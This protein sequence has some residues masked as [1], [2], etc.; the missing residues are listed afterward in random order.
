MKIPVS[1]NGMFNMADEVLIPVKKADGTVEKISLA[2]FQARQKARRKPVATVS[3]P[4]AR[5]VVAPRPAVSIPRSSAPAKIKEEPTLEELP[6]TGSGAPRVSQDRKVDAEAIVRKLNLQISADAR[7]RLIGLI[8]L[9]LKDVRGEDEVKEWL[10]RSDKQYGIGLDNATADKVLV[11]IGE[12]TKKNI[13][14]PVDAPVLKRPL[15]TPQTLLK[16]DQEPFPATS[17]PIN[18]FVHAPYGDAKKIFTTPKSLDD[19]AR[20][21]SAKIGDDIAGMIPRKEMPARAIVRDIT[22]AKPANLG[23][24]DEIRYFTLTDFRRLSANPSEAAS[25][26]AQKFTNLRDES[27]I[28]YMNALEAWRGSPLFNDY[29]GASASSLNLKKKVA[30]NLADKNKIQ[31]NEIKALIQ[32]EKDLL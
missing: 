17:S 21:E 26:L 28:L 10:V 15:G 4:V 29:I 14:A 1:L 9:R 25:R 18:S 13:S 31:M 12:F 20:S 27:Y 11:A 22:P 2:E 24:V 5:P 30:E 23:P 16:E 7:N 8:Q 19:L 6:G 32:M 3:A